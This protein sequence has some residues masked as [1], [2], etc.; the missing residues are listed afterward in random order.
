MDG[1]SD[2]CAKSSMLRA[3]EF[4]KIDASKVSLRPSCNRIV[5]SLNGE[6]V[7]H[8]RPPIFG[9]NALINLNQ[10]GRLLEFVAQRTG[11]T[12]IEVPKV[13]HEEETPEGYLQLRSVVGVMDY[14]LPEKFGKKE[15]F[16][17]LSVFLNAL[18]QIPVEDVRC[19]DLLPPFI[20]GLST[21]FN[22]A[23]KWV[24]QSSGK[25]FDLPKDL[26]E[27][28]QQILAPCRLDAEVFIHGDIHNYNLGYNKKG[29]LTG[30]FDFERARIAPR[31]YEMAQ[32]LWQDLCLDDPQ[33]KSQVRRFVRPLIDVY[34]EVSGHKVDLAQ[35]LRFIALHTL[36]DLYS[37][38]YFANGRDKMASYDRF[39]SA[40]Y[41]YRHAADF[42]AL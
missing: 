38:R 36:K 40:A 25:V 35:P 19:E 14:H 27:D 7:A 5:A 13:L 17:K 39:A 42:F 33:Q 2:T 37:S 15:V 9:N 1:M 20:P 29:E 11:H 4:A 3:L 32:F 34:Q 28:A 12:G 41:N 31:S 26:L 23:A 24:G 30:V 16:Q 21:D 22:E 8:L 6:M 10:E 18:H